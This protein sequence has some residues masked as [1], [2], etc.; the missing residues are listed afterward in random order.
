M[1]RFLM[2]MLVVCAGM[3]GVPAWAGP[4]G[5]VLEEVVVRA[6]QRKQ[7]LEEVPLAI[8]VL[9][10][11]FL[12]QHR[13]QHIESVVLATPGLSGWEQG[14]STPI[15]AIRG[16]SS[17][18][19][20]VGGEASVGL[21]VDE[22]YRGRINSTSVTMV[23]VEQVEVLKGPQGTLFGR[24]SSAGAILIR[25]NPPTDEN[26]LDLTVETGDNNYLGLQATAN[27]PLSDAWSLRFSGFSF[28]DHGA[29][30]N[31]WLHQDMGD[32]DTRGGQLALRYGADSV[33]AILRLASQQTHTGG[34]GYETL[35]PE[36]A[37]AGGVRPDPFDG[38]LATDI[39][40]YDDVESHDASLQVNW[41][42]AEGLRLTSITA[43]HHNDSPNLFDVDGSAIFLTS[44]GFTSRDSETLSQEFRLHGSGGRLDWVGGVILFDEDINTTIELGYSDTNQLSRF[45]L[46]APALE[47]VL[48]PCLDSVLETSKQR[49]DYFSAGAFA[50]LGWHLSS[51]LTLGAGLRYSYDDKKF[52][53][54]AAPVTSVITRLNSSE[55]N[56]SGN[57]LGYATDGWQHLDE[58]W[59]DWQPR[60]Y[61]NWQFSAD[62]NAFVNLAKGY[63]AGGFDPAATS[64]LSVFD[65]EKVWNLDL[66]VRGAALQ[67]RL[68]YQLSGFIYDYKD[69]Q[70]QV[71]ANGIAQTSNADGVDG[72]G[73]ELELHYTLLPGLTL[74]LNGSWLDAEFKDYKTDEGNFKGNRPILAPEYT[75]SASL[76]WHSSSFG[77]GALGAS[78]LSSYQSE[79]FFTVQNTDDAHQD[80]F[81]RHDARVSYFT[82][83]E[84]WQLDIFVRNLMNEEYRSF[85][86]D[87]GAGLVSRRGKERFWGIAASAH[88]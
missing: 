4:D 68:S 45:G 11:D 74:G 47:P 83:S 26:S 82:P 6:Q 44:A 60:L 48:G 53:Y 29:M 9:D 85:E 49:G 16:I 34:L 17:N 39:N 32:R 87:V 18:S 64:A 84:Q 13:L 79:V 55:Q 80:S 54:R 57:L 65:P 22:T 76:N 66:G 7:T 40:T 14:V 1:Y 56:P 63:K 69:Y 88:F 27:L 78:L 41:Q 81:Y 46:C 58:D 75:A 35:N 10:G 62:H 77:W 25:H 42:L 19:F 24:N 2:L 71:I 70:V 36:L 37:A 30:D 61:A 33:E 28:D 51:D 43:W 8:T 50:D 52:K 20:G 12:Q 15:F 5:K 72:H 59:D 21:F 38:V 73:M 67:Q 23:D 3:S 31:T 86:Q